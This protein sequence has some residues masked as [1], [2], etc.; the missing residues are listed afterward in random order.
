MAGDFR[1]VVRVWTELT[2]VRD[3]MGS[4]R[5]C[6]R[7]VRER[8]GRAGAPPSGPRRAR[9][10]SR[11]LLGAA[12]RRGSNRKRSLSPGVSVCVRVRHIILLIQ[13]II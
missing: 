7:C 6:V 9:A 4:M 1:A 3:P 8:R 11:R 13:Y 5:V 12:R 10:R 2:V